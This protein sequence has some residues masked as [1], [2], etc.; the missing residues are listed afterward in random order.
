MIVE[1]GLRSSHPLRSSE[2]KKSRVPGLKIKRLVSD[3]IVLIQRRTVGSESEYLER[4]TVV[5]TFPGDRAISSI[6]AHL[7]KRVTQRQ[8][9]PQNTRGNEGLIGKTSN[10][11]WRCV[12][13][14]LTE[15]LNSFWRNSTPR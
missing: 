7:A 1:G 5:F 14:R 9:C 6:S 10:L 13:R 8:F 15:A 2:R 4:S 11:S 12:L 3:V